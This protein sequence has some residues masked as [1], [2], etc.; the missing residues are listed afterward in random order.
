M[1]IATAGLNAVVA[2][3]TDRKASNAA[4]LA[5][6]VAQIKI[7]RPVIVTVFGYRVP[8]DGPCTMQE[9]DKALSRQHAQARRGLDNRPFRLLLRHWHMLFWVLVLALPVWQK[10]QQVEEHVLLWTWMLLRMLPLL[11][12]H[13]CGQL[14]AGD[15]KQIQFTFRTLCRLLCPPL[16]FTLCSLPRGTRDQASRSD[17][18]WCL[19][20]FR[21]TA[22]C[23]NETKHGMIDR[24][25]G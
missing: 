12:M 9:W 5:S 19:H 17:P 21:S 22:D 24:A 4:V 18:C 14:E 13:F 8:E 11:H 16:L 15:A 1:A 10:C 3:K 20:L 23:A 2:L 25:S 6:R 7:A